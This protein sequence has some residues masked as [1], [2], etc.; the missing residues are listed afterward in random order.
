MDVVIDT[1]I[2][3][4]NFS[5]KSIQIEALSAYLTK[6]DKF[7]IIPYVVENELILNY[8]KDLK[9][10]IKD[11]QSVAGEFHK[12][13]T[14]PE[15]EILS[16]AIKDLKGR[17]NEKLD[18]ESKNYIAYVK[19]QI[20]RVKIDTLPELDFKRIV[21]KALNKE[22]PFKLT[23]E[24]F[25]DTIIWES[26]LAYCKR[27]NLDSI[28]FVSNNSKDFGKEKLL[29]VLKEQ[30][31]SAGITVHYYNSLDAFIQ[32]RFKSI[33]NI[34]LEIDDIDIADLKLHAEFKLQEQ[35]SDLDKIFEKK[36]KSNIRYSAFQGIHEF[37][38]REIEEVIVKDV[39]TD[40]KYIQ[41]S[42]LCQIG[43]VCVAEHYSE[44]VN[45]MTGDYDYDIDLQ[46][47][48][49]SIDCSVDISLK[50]DETGFHELEVS[51]IELL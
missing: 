8:R 27:N 46:L 36:S 6:T 15:Y 47:E 14:T 11:L 33:N 40:F 24:G 25:K 10:S 30:A 29:P 4:A 9:K 16:Q 2:F 17:D 37:S 19:K 23:G 31:I 5:L 35:L 18:E 34:V 3:Q 41:A 49:L 50:Y 38:I 45:S 43:V 26:V 32:D 7:L 44:F 51:L 20:G 42:I 39:A 48:E 22:K 12:C 1:N 21:D 13:V 28:I